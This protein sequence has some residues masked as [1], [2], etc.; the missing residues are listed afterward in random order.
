[1]ESLETVAGPGHTPSEATKLS[2]EPFMFGVVTDV[3]IFWQALSVLNAPIMVLE[4]VTVPCLSSNFA[5]SSSTCL[6]S[7]ELIC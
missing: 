3:G 7:E 4:S 2:C 5:A 6:L 1:M